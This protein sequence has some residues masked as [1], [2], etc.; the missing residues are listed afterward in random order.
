[1]AKKN[2]EETIKD[3]VKE[4]KT[5]KIFEKV[6]DNQTIMS[7]HSLAKKGY[8][9]VVE[10]VV[11]TGKEAHVFRAKDVSGNFR[12]VKIYKIETSGFRNI[13]KYLFGDKRFSNIK[14]TKK[15]IVFNWAKKEFKNLQLCLEAGAS[16][17]K[18]MMV[19]DNVLVMDFVGKNGLAAKSLREE[20]PKEIQTLED[21]YK[22]TIEFIA[23]IFYL[24]ELIHADLSEYNILVQDNKLYFIDI[25]QGVLSI[26]ENAKEYFERDVKNVTNYFTKQGLEKT[27]KQAIEDIK[28]IG[29]KIRNKKE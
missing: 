2:N 24:K 8:F 28:R 29:Q 23:R 6:F 10:F 16:T 17:P 11:S 15:E 27:E 18:P 26:H 7:L 9:D 25:G 21:Y 1:M 14:R 4:E 19:K 20:N 22:Q 3:I 5:R 13:D 12:A